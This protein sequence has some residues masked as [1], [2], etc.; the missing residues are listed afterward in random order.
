MWFSG[1]GGVTKFDSEEFHSYS[2]KYQGVAETLQI[3]GQA[4]YKNRLWFVGFGGKLTVYENGEFHPFKH[5]DA[6][7]TLLARDGCESLYI[8]S[9][10][11]LHIGV[12][13]VGYFK[14]FSNGELKEICTVQTGHSGIYYHEVEGTLLVFSI[15]DELDEQPRFPIFKLNENL[16][17]E[18]ITHLYA[19]GEKPFTK[20]KPRL[21]YLN[22]SNGDLIISYHNHLVEI[23]PDTVLHHLT[24]APITALTEDSKNGLWLT[25]PE[26]ENVFHLPNGDL[27]TNT[28]QGILPGYRTHY[29]YEDQ[30][31]G[32]WFTT[33]ENGV[34]YMPYSNCKVATSTKPSQPLENS[35]S[36]ID[37]KKGFFWG[38][39]AKGVF[40]EFKEDTIY[41]YQLPYPNK[42]VIVLH[43]S[44]ENETLYLASGSWVFEITQHRIKELM[45][46][47]QS[48][49]VVRSMEF[50]QPDSAI[51][52]S[53]SSVLHK[54]QDGE[55]TMST[56]SLPLEIMDICQFQ[57]AVYVATMAGVWKWQKNQWT[58]LK[59][60]FKEFDDQVYHLAK[61]DQALWV[62]TRQT[63]LFRLENDCLSRPKGM[64]NLLVYGVE[65]THISDSSLTFL[66][67]G[68]R[69]LDIQAQQ[70]ENGYKE[71][72]YPSAPGVK[73]SR[74]EAITKIGKRGKTWLF[75]RNEEL[76][77]LDTAQGGRYPA[78][79]VVLDKININKT[80]YELA[81]YISLP[82]D[83]N[84]IQIAYKGLSFHA[85]GIVKYEYQMTNLEEWT[86]TTDSEIRFTSLNPG[87]YTFQIR[88]YDKQSQP[89]PVETIHFTILPAYYQTWWFRLLIIGS[90]SIIIWRLFHIRVKQVKKKA[91][92]QKE[93]H[94]S[95]HQALA[96][97]MNPH[98]IF[99]SLTSIQ[100][101]TLE[102]KGEKAADY[103]SEYAQFMRLIME[104]SGNDL[105]ALKSELETIKIYLD[106]EKLRCDGKIDYSLSIDPNIDQE[107]ILVPTML[108]LPYL[109]NAIWHGLMPLTDKTGHL[110]IEFSESNLG[111]EVVIKDN[112]IGREKAQK[113]GT[114]NHPGF[115]SRGMSLTQSRIELISQAYHVNITI[116]T[117]DL[118][119]EHLDTVG[120]KVN[121]TIPSLK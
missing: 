22:R 102:N 77:T 94:S 96:L 85:D 57:E 24:P 71:I 1:L 113:L 39:E 81:S 76:Y 116:E 121:L 18:L 51:W 99:N 52:V 15:S 105:I 56:P 13:K 41:S 30:Y 32:Y 108:F 4:D 28:W 90:I 11:T 70:N 14:L 60:S 63:G 48:N 44:R 103:L 6:L 107:E 23:K 92:L 114:T 37:L 42:K 79:K 78:P 53:R 74:F 93:L 58:D 69:F 47:D 31:G 82:S 100:Q 119:N 87:T 66:A 106:L 12:R 19:P 55:I 88:T 3:R 26:L 84:E 120:T 16:E 21:R 7:G 109:E 29:I 38:G 83:S 86:S 9:N 118:K 112:G 72:F 36:E 101:F 62:F 89:S 73:N 54:I 110:E 80:P 50:S 34:F 25:N 59:K 95:Q 2:Y 98:V 17:S 75:A 43:H 97:R 61:F 8:D 5:N 46:G 68:G 10:E 40:Y 115:K 27:S 33:E 35:L 117:E 91:I 104:N 45:K 64:S 20:H 49:N 65:K 111:L 67:F